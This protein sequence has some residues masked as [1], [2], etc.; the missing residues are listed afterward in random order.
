MSH[1]ALNS[2]Q[3]GQQRLF[4]IGGI[5][6]KKDYPQPGPRPNPEFEQPDEG[7]IGKYL[8]HHSSP[9]NRSSIQRQGLVPKDPQRSSAK[10]M[11]IPRSQTPEGVYLGPHT[12]VAHGMHDVWA[13]DTNKVRLEQ[14]PDDSSNYWGFHYSEHPVPPDAMKL[15]QK[16][17]RPS[18]RSGYDIWGGG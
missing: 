15:I 12:H 3:F 5:P 18:K 9:R 4:G 1:A 17:K 8:Y 2:E 16:G 13:V 7:H 10:G 11:G 6:T 14:D